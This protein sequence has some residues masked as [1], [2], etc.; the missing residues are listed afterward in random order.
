[1]SIRLF[2][3]VKTDRPTRDDFLSNAA[4]SKPPINLDPE[5][6]RTHDGISTFTPLEIARKRA[7]RFQRIGPFL[8]ELLL[9]D[10]SPSIRVERT[11][12]S[13]GHYTV[14]GNP[15]ELFALVV[16]VVPVEPSGEDERYGL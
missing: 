12:S 5:V 4:R 11:F 13:E 9:P 10:E 15:D 8:A 16:R 6:L 14:W 1:M 7:L 3:A 2:R